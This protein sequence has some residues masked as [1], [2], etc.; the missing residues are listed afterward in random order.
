MNPVR[1]PVSLVHTRTATELQARET[2]RHTDINT[3][4][5]TGKQTCRQTCKQA[6]RST[7][8]D[9]YIFSLGENVMV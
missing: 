2:G 4:R 5:Q 9:R 7:D 8:T 1:I 6:D 3:S